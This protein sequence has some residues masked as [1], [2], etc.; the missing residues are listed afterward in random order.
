MNGDE[1][2]MFSMLTK[3]KV[4][5]FKNVEDLPL[6]FQRNFEVEKY[7]YFEWKTFDFLDPTNFKLSQ[8][9]IE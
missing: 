7:I 4:S 5:N 2:S 8:M 1:K 3:F 6:M 9:E